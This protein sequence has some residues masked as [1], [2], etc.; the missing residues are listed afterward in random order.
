M[1]DRNELR[2]EMI[3]LIYHQAYADTKGRIP[4]KMNFGHRQCNKESRIRI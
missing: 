2:E 3:K 4:P 1:I